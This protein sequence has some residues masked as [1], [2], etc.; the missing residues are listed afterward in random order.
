LH[1]LGF[2]SSIHEILPFYVF[3]FICKKRKKAK[4]F[5]K[6]EKNSNKKKKKKEAT[7]KKKRKKMKG[8]FNS[9]PFIRGSISIRIRIFSAFDVFLVK[10][11][12]LHSF[13]GFSF[14][15]VK[16]L[17]HLFP[18]TFK[19]TLQPVKSPLDCPCAHCILSGREIKYLDK[20]MV[21]C[22][23]RLSLE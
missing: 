18:L 20:P 12:S 5:R 1:I 13:Y 6:T 16:A 15:I 2:E 22:F 11:S 10:C 17:V 3:I 4:K 8:L 19:P 7:K 9:F 23:I 21:D 14:H